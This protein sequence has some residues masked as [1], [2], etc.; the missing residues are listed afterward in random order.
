M[1]EQNGNKDGVQGTRLPLGGAGTPWL[2]SLEPALPNWL[3]LGW[4]G[5]WGE[6]GRSPAG[7]LDRL[8]IPGHCPSLQGWQ[9][10]MVPQAALPIK[11]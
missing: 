6:E 9:W 5:R 3:S 8:Q 7:F 4:L 10:F 1:T 11:S 2:L